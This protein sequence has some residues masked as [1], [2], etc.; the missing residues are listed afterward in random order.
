MDTSCKSPDKTDKVDLL[1]PVEAKEA[2]VMD[3]RCSVAKELFDHVFVIY[4]VEEL[5][6]H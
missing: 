6:C 3:E 1:T 4:V 5:F 2:M